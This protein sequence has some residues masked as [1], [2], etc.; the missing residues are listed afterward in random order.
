MLGL[1]WYGASS[2][3]YE[4]T[5]SEELT[6]AAAAALAL[7]ALIASA[8]WLRRRCKKTAALALALCGAIPVAAV[9]GIIVLYVSNPPDKR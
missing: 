6:Y 1:V 5:N 3:I 4:G 2:A 9:Y 8:L 7:L